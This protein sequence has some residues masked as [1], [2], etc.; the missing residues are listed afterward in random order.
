MKDH[1][2]RSIRL[3]AYDY[4]R[5]GAYFIT[6]CVQ[7]RQCVFGKILDGKLRL[8]PAGVMVECKW[9]DIPGRF[10]ASRLGP[11]VIMPNHL[12]G[13]I[14]INASHP[15]EALP[16]PR[17]ASV[18][19]MIQWFKTGT[20][21]DYIIGVKHRD[22]P[23]FDGKLWQ[24]NYWEHIVRTEADYERISLYIEGN[25]SSWSDDRLRPSQPDWTQKGRPL[26]D[27]PSDA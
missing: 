27:R 17:S 11:F 26:E 4:A 21:Y 18:S 6:I 15:D 7:H 1:R 12:H 23:P 2:R 20:T 3:K 10:P 9:L 14:L 5:P 25:P 22:W 24:R 13:I 16:E 19:S 8:S